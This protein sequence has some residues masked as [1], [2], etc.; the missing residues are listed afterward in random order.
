M[1]VDNHHDDRAK[2]SG[3]TSRSL[4]AGAKLDDP[5]AWERIVRLYAPLVASWCRRWGVA[6]QDMGDLLQEVFSAVA[7]HL[8]QLERQLRASMPQHV[9]DMLGQQAAYM[10]N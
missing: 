1:T 8:E 10:S 7:S 4:L 6:E 2:W 3:S 9:M 5:S